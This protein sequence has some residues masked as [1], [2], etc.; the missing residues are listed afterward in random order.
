MWHRQ[1]GRTRLYYRINIEKRTEG[2]FE[3]HDVPAVVAAIVY[4]SQWLSLVISHIHWYLYIYLGQPFPFG[5]LPAL[6]TPIASPT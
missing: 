1:G 5:R 4:I 2:Q 3:E 6:T